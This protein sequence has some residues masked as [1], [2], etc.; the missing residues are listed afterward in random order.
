MLKKKLFNFRPFFF[1]AISIALGIGAGYM[2]Y[3]DKILW[4]ILLTVIFMLFSASTV[5]LTGG[6]IKSKLLFLIPFVLI[7][8]FGAGIFCY[9]V[10]DYDNANL[11]G[12]YYEVCGKVVK[13]GTTDY[14][15]TLTL[16]NVSIRGNRTGELR[17]GVNVYVFGETNFDIG[18]VVAFE[19]YL[20]DNGALYEERLSA[21]NI[22]RGIKYTAS[23]DSKSIVKT[24]E[25]KNLFEIAHIYLRNS[26]KSGMGEQENAV[27]YGLLLGN[28]SDVEDQV[29]TS[30]RSAGVAHI[31]AVSGLH[32]GFLATV[33]NFIFN[34]LKVN[35]LVKAII[36]T[37]V[38]LFYSGV[39]GFSASSLRATVMSAVLL[40]SSIRG[41]RYD[42]LSSVGIACTLILMCSPIN[43]FCVGFQLSFGVVLG[44]I[45]L[46]QPISRIFSF[47]PRKLSNSLGAVISAQ[48]VGIPICLYAF[49]QF[50]IVAIIANL[51]FI[52]I[53]G[54][55]FIM[56][57][58]TTIIGGIAGI[59][60]IALFV[61]NYI[62]KFI[63]MLITAIDYDI[64]IV[65]GFT[66][67]IFAV[68]YYLALLIPCGYLNLNKIVKWI[69]T[70]VC[71]VACAVGTAVVSV[72]ENSA[73]KV[74]VVGSDKVCSTVINNGN[75][76][77]MIVSDCGNIVPLSRFKRLSERENIE[78]IDTLIFTE[79]HNVDMQLFITRVKEVFELERI[80]YYGETDSVGEEVIRKSFGLNIKSFNSGDEIFT[81]TE[82]KYALNG[83]AVECEINGRK[84]AVLSEFGKDYAGYR[85]LD[86]VYDYMIAVDYAEYIEKHYS[87]KKFIS[88]RNSLLYKSAENNGT[89]TLRLK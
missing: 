60:N 38:L 49:G 75:E 28:T 55:I 2:F 31:F 40:F 86:G 70:S 76:N 30:Y 23:V 21:T 42:G 18:D 16:E 20:Q 58:I 73:P 72:K 67:G 34:K 63:N 19:S 51:L 41:N 46:A 5:L 33:L 87:P 85:G 35:R 4:G 13:A 61:P 3:F 7:F 89:I 1:I 14:G 52:P 39:C 64:F 69:A 56:L 45:L 77:I 25:D 59:S 50:S 78:K 36:I 71:I 88:Y 17:Y 81:Q 47:L 84:I 6:E 65:G 53:V 48:V 57:F 32:I 66:F 43:M 82:C 24:G 68:L 29:I 74:Y 62:F 26:I 15:Q 8:G 27:A 12:H 11:D 22:E 54:V 80:S 9:Q 83:Y 37:L 44:M 10:S 79:G